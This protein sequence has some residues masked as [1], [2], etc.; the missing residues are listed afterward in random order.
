MWPGLL[1]SIL[2]SNIHIVLDS[3]KSSKNDR[4]NRNLIAGSSTKRW[5]TIPFEDFSR[6]K[7]I[8]DLTID[9][10]QECV[11]KI[12][13]IFSSRYKDAPYLDEAIKLVNCIDPLGSNYLC[14]IYLNFLNQ[15]KNL[16]IPLPKIIYSSRLL[17]N[18]DLTDFTTPLDLVNHLLESVEASTYLAAHNVQSYSNKNEYNVSNVLFQNFT[19]IY[20]DQYNAS[21]QDKEFIP[22]LSIL[23]Y[24][25]SIGLN[26]LDAYLEKCNEWS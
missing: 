15:L 6:Y 4:Y 8:Q 24:I 21:R 20:Y 3:V 22:Y 5:L 14:D 1:K 16:G 17:E 25:A 18:I 12:V 23:D 2:D 9:N 10:S 19:P 11:K 26:D 13:N 7:S